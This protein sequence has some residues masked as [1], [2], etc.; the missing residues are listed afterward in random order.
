V[1]IAHWNDTVGMHMITDLQEHPEPYVTTSE[2]ADYWRV[3]RKQILKQIEAGTLK[4]V[5]LP[6][7]RLRI[8]TLD[9]IR[10]ENMATTS[11]SS[12]REAS[13]HRQ[14]RAHQKPY[15]WSG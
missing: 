10:F 15:S 13:S 3:S 4:T 2:L 14:R 9:A 12:G 7:W 11:P 6:R 5:R 1:V 8:R